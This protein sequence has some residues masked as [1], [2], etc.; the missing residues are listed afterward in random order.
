M[1]KHRS[2]S[3]L[4]RDSANISELYLN[5]LDQNQIASE[6][7]ISQSK[8]SERLKEYHQGWIEQ[9]Q[10]DVGQRRAEIEL[11]LRYLY[12]KSM[13]AFGL[14]PYPGH[15]KNAMG[16]LAGISKLHGLDQQTLEIT[17][18]VG[19]NSFNVHHAIQSGELEQAKAELDQWHQNITA[20]PRVPA[21]SVRGDND[22]GSDENTRHLIAN[23]GGSETIEPLPAEPEPEPAYDNYLAETDPNSADFPLTI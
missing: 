15:I 16:A 4:A 11:K 20:K 8:V 19:I 7:G 17:G 13:S 5:G 6:L 18:N 9:G 23:P 21:S 3:Q 12:Q 1:A 14:K 2:P 22:S 10:A